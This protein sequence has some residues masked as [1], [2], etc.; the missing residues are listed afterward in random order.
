MRIPLAV[1]A[2][3]AL[4]DAPAHSQQPAPPTCAAAEHRALDFWIGE[5]DAYATGTDTLVGRSSIRS[6]DAGCVI[7]EQWTGA[8]GGSGRSLN[9]YDRETQRWEQFWVDSSGGLV[10][11]VGGPT[12]NGMQLTAERERSHH[13]PGVE[14]Q[15]RVTLTAQPDGAV[16]QVGETS[17]DGQTWT[18]RYD[19]TYRRRSE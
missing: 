4:L 1:I 8:R 9:I 3:F 16:R 19:Y 13:A 12:E 14:Y 6:E 7:I 5:W 11:F 18:L 2:A 15:S 17:G 10:H